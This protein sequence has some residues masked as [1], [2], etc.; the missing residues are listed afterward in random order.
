M[1]ESNNQE[2][3]S[4]SSSVANESLTAA[5]GLDNEESRQAELASISLALSSVEASLREKESM[6][7]QFVQQENYDE[8]DKIQVDLD[9]FLEHKRKLIQRAEEL[10]SSESELLS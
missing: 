10:G 4:S 5:P 7:E 9:A 6:I 2:S 8:A 1:D 3:L